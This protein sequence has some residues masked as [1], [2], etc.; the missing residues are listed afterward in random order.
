VPEAT[1][2]GLGGTGYT[3]TEIAE[4]VTVLGLAQLKLDVMM[5]LMVLALLKLD[6]VK[7][8]PGI[9]EFSPFTCHW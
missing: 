8:G 3:V 6:T 4:L 2:S 5:Q 9:P 1:T 7:V